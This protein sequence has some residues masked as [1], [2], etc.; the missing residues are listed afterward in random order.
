MEFLA[1]VKNKYP[2]PQDM[3][4]GLMDATIAWMHKYE[5]RLEHTWGFAGLQSGGGVANVE[6][7]EELDEIMTEF[8]LGPFSDI[9]IYPLVDMESS[10]KHAKQIAQAMALSAKG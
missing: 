10:L 6:S 4:P 8:P 9:E 1:I 3:V 5:G 2:M 7:A